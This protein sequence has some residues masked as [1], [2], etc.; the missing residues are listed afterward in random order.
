MQ[1]RHI[2][3]VLSLAFPCEVFA[4][5][6]ESS[7]GAAV[8]NDAS[9]TYYNPAALTLLK[10]PQIVTIDS[11]AYFHTDFKGQATQ[12]ATGFTQTGRSTSNTH[13]YLPSLYFGM[14]FAK[15][16]SLGVAIISNDFNR[17]IDGNSVLRYAQANNQTVDLNAVAAMGYQ[18]NP[19]VSIGAGLNF[20]HANFTLKPIFGIPSLN[21]PDSQSD[22]ESSGNSFGGEVGVLYQPQSGTLIGMNYRTAIIYHLSGTSKFESNPPIISDDYR[23]KFYVPSRIVLSANHFV[24]KNLGFIATVQHI[25]W[26]IFNTLNIQ[27]IATRQGITNASTPY[28]FKNGWLFTVGTHYKFT[29]QWLLRIAANYTQSP[30]NGSYQVTNGDSV[31]LGFSM[32]YVINKYVTVDGSYAHSFTRDKDIGIVTG[33]NVIVGVNRGERDAVSVK[34]TVGLG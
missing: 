1:L 16:F 31:L 23:Y 20:T 9:A 10:T 13:Y 21:I 24:T 34:A 8:I 11:L 19:T 4:S 7:I 26:D 14:P 32:S 33:R 3:L 12:V 27:G 25:Q 18:I 5:F 30:G 28:H 22:N 2:V 15:K 17:D 29:P 6:I